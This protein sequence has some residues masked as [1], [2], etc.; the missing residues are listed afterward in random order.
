MSEEETQ[1]KRDKC[2]GKLVE[3]ERLNLLNV[4]PY[5]D[6]PWLRESFAS[7]SKLVI[8]GGEN[9]KERANIQ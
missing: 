6:A 1:N 5:T 3:K 4:L 8:G 2:K 7:I 9:K